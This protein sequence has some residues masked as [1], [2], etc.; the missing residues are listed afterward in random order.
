ML[1]L[2]TALRVMS[3]LPCQTHATQSSDLLGGYSR[4]LYVLCRHYP[5]RHMLPNQVTRYTRMLLETALRVMSS[6]PCSTHATQ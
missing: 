5:V 2:E 3:L 4:L 1:L 6:L